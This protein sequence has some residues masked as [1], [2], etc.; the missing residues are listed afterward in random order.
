MLS[1][2]MNSIEKKELEVYTNINN[3]KQK[4]KSE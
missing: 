1:K 4:K 2:T 3:V